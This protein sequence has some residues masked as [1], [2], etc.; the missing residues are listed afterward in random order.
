MDPMLLRDL[1]AV[2]FVV[3]LQNPGDNESARKFISDVLVKVEKNN[4]SPSIVVLLNK[5][6]PGKELTLNENINSWLQWWD[7]IY[8]DHRA[9]FYLTSILDNS[10]KEALAQTLL[11]TL[12]DIVFKTTIKQQF[13]LKAANSL[14]PLVLQLEENLKGKD[15][16]S[17]KAE[18]YKNAI[19]FGYGAAKLLLNA[20]INYMQGKTVKV[21]QTDKL[22][23]LKEKD[24][25]LIVDTSKRNVSVHLNCPLPKAMQKTPLICEITHGLF[26]GL[27]KL[28]GMHDITLEQTQIRDKTDFCIVKLNF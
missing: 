16:E 11:F 19:P 27:G 17:L 28:L 25:K 23:I 18:L 20:W 12:P 26:E 8:P 4:E 13:I 15:I 9:T 3:D 21:E 5:F 2:I 22:G 14:Y 1:R 24:I 6:D 7:E 10:A